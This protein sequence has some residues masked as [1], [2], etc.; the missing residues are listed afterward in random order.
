M[1]KK[2][3]SVARGNHLFLSSNT[4]GSFNTA[5]EAFGYVNINFII[6]SHTCPSLSNLV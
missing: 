5:Y 3:F 2:N 1:V 4:D 6:L